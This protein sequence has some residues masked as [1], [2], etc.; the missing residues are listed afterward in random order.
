MKKTKVLQ[1]AAAAALMAGALTIGAKHADASCSSLFTRT[2]TNTCTN[3]GATVTHVM[4]S[5]VDRFEMS[6]TG[7]GFVRLECMDS[8]GHQTG[9]LNANSSG[10]WDAQTSISIYGCPRG[11]PLIRASRCGPDG[12]CADD[13]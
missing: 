4:G 7:T 6:A 13:F 12:S 9:N 5:S 10:A 1:I 2:G 3:V 11:Y 8:A